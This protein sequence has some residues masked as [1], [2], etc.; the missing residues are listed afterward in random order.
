MAK[1]G[2]NN[3]PVYAGAA[4]ACVFIVM[5]GLVLSGALNG[6]GTTVPQSGTLSSVSVSASGTAKGIPTQ[7]VVDLFVN[8]TGST[9]AAATANLSARMALFNKTVYSYVGGNMSLVKTNYYNVGKQYVYPY[10]NTSNAVVPYQAQE[11]ITVTLLQASKLNGFLAN[12]TSVPGLQVQDVSA[13]LSD[14]QVSELRQVALKSAIANATS[15]ATSI[16]GNVKI[17]NTTIT[18]G[19]YYAVPYPIYASG[20][21]GGVAVGPTIGNLYYNGTTSVY[22][23]IEATFYYRK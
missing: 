17:V 11:S 22:E 5:V 14:S 2:S 13:A 20:S 18:V 15:Q 1:Q 9:T 21:S 19:S 16:I 7:A 8:A 4:V 3:G 12:I 23:N 10:P 6:G